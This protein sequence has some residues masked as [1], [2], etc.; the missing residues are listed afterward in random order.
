MSAPIVPPVV[1]LAEATAVAV[2]F[3][4]FQVIAKNAQQDSS[5]KVAPPHA[6]RAQ[7]VKTA[8]QAVLH[9]MRPA[10]KFVLL[11]HRMTIVQMAEQL[12]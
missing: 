2:N 4:L 11:G 12:V 3:D 1:R 8:V 5:A 9:A 6:N 7:V 10:P